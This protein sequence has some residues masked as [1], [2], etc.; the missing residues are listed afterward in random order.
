MDFNGAPAPDD[1]WPVDPEDQGG[2]RDSRR[3][4]AGPGVHPQG[5]REDM[6]GEGLHPDHNVLRPPLLRKRQHLVTLLHLRRRGPP[7]G[8]GPREGGVHPADRSG[9]PEDS[10]PPDVAGRIRPRHREPLRDGLVPKGAGDDD[11]PAP[12]ARRLQDALQLPEG[13]GRQARPATRL[14]TEGQ[15]EGQPLP[16]QDPGVR[17]AVRREHHLPDQDPRRRLLQ[18]RGNGE[19]RGDRAEP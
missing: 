3:H 10:L 2:R 7:R 1:P 14:R 18:G 4:G 9:A 6:R 5:G 19:P 13:R 11:G 17:G 15:G 16:Q 8:R 12:G